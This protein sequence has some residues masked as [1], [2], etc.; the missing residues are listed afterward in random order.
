[1]S[2]SRFETREFRILQTATAKSTNPVVV[3]VVVVVVVAAV[4]EQQ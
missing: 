3:V 4:A 2:W 1:V